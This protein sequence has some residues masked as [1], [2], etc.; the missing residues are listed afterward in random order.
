MARVPAF[1]GHQPTTD[2]APWSAESRWRKGAKALGIS[3]EAY[4]DQVRAGNRWCSY[5]RRWQ[6]RAEFR[7]HKRYGL[8]TVCLESE[9]ARARAYARAHYVPAAQ[10]RSA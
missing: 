5:C 6:S 1:L 9:R 10:R 2:R 3:F 7:P 4:C 8:N